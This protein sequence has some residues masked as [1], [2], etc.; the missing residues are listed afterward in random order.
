MYQQLI[1]SNDDIYLLNA[2][3]V[4]N[5]FPNEFEF[6]N[7]IDINKDEEKIVQESKKE[8]NTL[9]QSIKNI[10]KVFSPENN[11]TKTFL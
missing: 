5:W 11:K 10:N 6:I 1:Y 8:R 7:I 2:N 4:P 9:L 3:L